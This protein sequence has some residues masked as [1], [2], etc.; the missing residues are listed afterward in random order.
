MT[1]RNRRLTD[2]P[3][4]WILLAAAVLW[5]GLFASLAAI[6]RHEAE[7]EVMDLAITEAR[8]AYQKDVSYRLWNASHGGVYVPVTPDFQPNPYLTGITNRDITT[9]SGQRLTLVNPAYMTRLV[10]ELGRKEFGLQAHITSLKPLSPANAP[11]SWETSALQR[12]ATNSPAPKEIAEI[13]LIDGERHLR[14]IAPLVTRE[15]C[16]KCHGSQ[17]HAVGD[18]R[19]GLSVSVPLDRTYF[20]GAAGAIRAWRV[21]LAGIW[22]LGLVGLAGVGALMNRRRLER[23]EAL[24]LLQDG[25][26]RLRHALAAGGMGAWDWDLRSNLVQ[27]TA[28]HEQL[29]GLPTGSFDGRLETFYR[30]VAPGD[31]EAVKQH[32]DRI[33]ADGSSCDVTFRVIW[34]DGSIHW[35][36]AQGECRRDAQN[37]PRQVTGVVREITKERATRERLELQ[38]MVLDQITDTVTVTDLQGRI[39]YLNGAMCHLL[40]EE[41]EAVVGKHIESLGPDAEQAIMQRRIFDITTTLGSWQG[42]VVLA[43]PRDRPRTVHLKTQL[44]LGHAGEPVALCGIGTDITARKQAEA[45]LHARLKLSEVA[46]R[47]TLDDL[48][49]ASLDACEELT[50]SSIGFFHFVHPDQKHLTLQTWSTNTLKHMCKADGKG[51]HYPIHEAGVWVDCFHTRAPV[52]HNDYNRLI[53]R[54]GMPEGHAVVTRELVVPI[55]RDGL[56]TAIMGVG[57]K[58]TNYNQED[59]KLAE[60]L[61]SIAMDLVSRR[62]AEQAL[63]ESD[64]NYRRLFNDATEGI[65]IADADTGELLDVNDAFIQLIKRTRENLIGSPQKSLHPDVDPK[66]RYSRTF[67]RHRSDEHDQILP[68][69][70]L[71]GTG[72]IRE[73]EIKAQILQLGSRKVVQGFFRDATDRL[74]AERERERLNRELDRKNQELQNVLFAASHDLRAPLL[75]VQG[76]T[77]RLQEAC[78]RLIPLIEPQAQQGNESARLALAILQQEVPKSAAFV[79]GGAEKMDMLISGMLR[80]SRLGQVT[81]SP[82]PLDMDR[83]MKQILSSLALQLEEAGASVHVD[84]LPNVTGDPTLISQVFANLIDNA[85]KYRSRE[86]PLTLSITGRTDGTKCVFC[87]ED[88]GTGI[89]PNRADKIWELFAR[90]N[91]S[92]ASGDGLGLNLVKRIV[93]RHRGEV[94]MEPN[95]GGGCRFFVSLPQAALQQPPP[96]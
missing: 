55:L 8:A 96:P 58:A 47:G 37:A 31:R 53:H 63:R 66:D 5:T 29:F 73:V 20:P 84:P 35:M 4:A 86:R 61:A 11:D 95:P 41:P 74:K 43:S 85:I 59:V 69:Y 54:K 70:I 94:H 88:N 42:E 52:I 21:T 6:G 15:Q 81:M 34:P 18:I 32:L 30:C 19:G 1:A 92:L 82:Q 90:L 13:S 26:E 39:T 38:A 89:P 3:V 71:T 79:R 10:H 22:A 77:H 62:R 78:A 36:H 9:V 75:N 45:L 17:G 2:F 60:E 68:E 33:R 76:H 72:E 49:Q 80:L 28:E 16:L 24:A 83:V 27:W 87:V 46:N 25:E 51:A 56:V 50:H 12:F 64:A 93:D 67:A 14:F 7:H 48:M 65:A 44:I 57:N 40:R 91:P 23:R